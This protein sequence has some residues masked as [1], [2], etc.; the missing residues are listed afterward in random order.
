MLPRRLTRGAV[1]GT[2][3]RGSVTV[4]MTATVPRWT[5]FDQ[6]ISLS[7]HLKNG[8]ALFLRHTWCAMTIAINL[9]VNDGVGC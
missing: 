9:K 8:N 6:L 3:N 4:R 1:G 7:P 2:V 5:V